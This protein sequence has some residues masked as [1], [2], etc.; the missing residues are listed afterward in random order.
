[1]NMSLFDQL[2][3]FADEAATEYNELLV[4]ARSKVNGP[5]G[6]LRVY[7]EGTPAYD[8]LTEAYTVQGIA[9]GINFAIQFLRGLDNNEGF[10]E[11]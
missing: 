9:T 6:H 11:E 10:G 1:M 8:N 5:D 4:M 2:Q 3:T 7:T